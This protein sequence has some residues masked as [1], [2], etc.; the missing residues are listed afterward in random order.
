MTPHTDVDSRHD[1]GTSGGVASAHRPDIAAA[2]SDPAEA[3]V[4]WSHVL[5]LA[6]VLA[7]ANGFWIISMRGAIGAIERTSAPFTAWWL[8]STLLVP[9]YVVAVLAASLMAHR[10]FGARPH[11]LA[12][13]ASTGAAVALFAATAGTLLQIASSWFDS[14]LQRGDLH[15]M[16]TVHPGCDAACVS[17]RVQATLHLELKGVLIALVLMVLTDLVLVGLMIAFRGGDIVL[18][19]LARRPRWRAG[20]DTQVLLAAGLLGAA[21]IHAAVVPEHLHEWWAA[22]TFFIVLTLA[23]TAGAAAVLTRGP[24]WRVPGLVAAIVVSA[25]PLLVWT[26]SRTTGVPFGPEAWEPEA[27]GVADVLSCLLEVTSLTLAILLLRRHHP[28]R[29]WTRHHLALGLTAVLAATCIGVGGSTLPGI[30][31]FST[32]GGHHDHTELP[33]G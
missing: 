13:V 16:G 24:G 22:G 28:A 29:P 33:P 7:F 27:I 15:H 14:T 20:A 18:A 1:L 10:R 19:R 21:A 12:A 11:G 30:G 8:E 4:A 6:I 3:A 31:A 17:A 23:E 26:I 5:P 25:G 9:V 2:S 32:L